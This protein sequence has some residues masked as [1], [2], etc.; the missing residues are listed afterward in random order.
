[1][2]SLPVELGEEKRQIIYIINTPSKHAKFKP[3][4]EIGAIS[5]EKLNDST[6]PHV[7]DKAHSID[8]RDKISVDKIPDKIMDKMRILLAEYNTIFAKTSYDIKSTDLIE[9]S[10]ETEGSNPIRHRPYRTPFKL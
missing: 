2:L 6:E 9:H 5:M 1:M 8:A 3:G 10:I 7:R 4:N